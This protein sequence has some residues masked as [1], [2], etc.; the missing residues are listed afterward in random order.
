MTLNRRIGLGFTLGVDATGGS[1]FTTI[2]SIVD[3]FD[4]D[5]AAA[6]VADTSV[7]A[8]L[9][10][11]KAKSQIDPGGLTFEVAW[12]PDFPANATLV[13][14]FKNLTPIPNWQISY[15][16]GDQGAG[17]IVVDTFKAHHT[18]M[19]RVIKKDKLFTC[20][21]TLVKTGQPG[22]SGD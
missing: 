12:D 5:E 16:A 17:S 13:T 1:S 15:P 4:E 3:G 9:Y 20:K 14:T 22:F 19:G 21:I 2:G 8:D 6:D 10:K 7:L 11:L 18:K